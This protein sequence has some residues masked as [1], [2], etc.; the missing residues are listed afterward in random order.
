[1]FESRP[2]TTPLRF[3]KSLPT[4]F[5]SH[6]PFVNLLDAPFQRLTYYFLEGVPANRKHGGGAGGGQPLEN[7][8]STAALKEIGLLWKEYYKCS[9]LNFWLLAGEL[10]LPPVPPYKL[11]V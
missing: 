6:V 8:F 3:P 4:L 7:P 2:E 5:H 9:F 1:M 11:R 10:V